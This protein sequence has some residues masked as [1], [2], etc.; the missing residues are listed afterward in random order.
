MSAANLETLEHETRVYCRGKHV[1]GDRFYHARLRALP[2]ESSLHEVLKHVKKVTAGLE[3]TA[4]KRQAFTDEVKALPESGTTRP[5]KRPGRRTRSSRPPSRAPSLR[6]FRSRLRRAG[7]RAIVVL[8]R[9]TTWVT[10][11]SA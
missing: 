4:F 8:R 7:I 1:K 5:W 6:R 11:R 9:F 10:G 3:K 2:V